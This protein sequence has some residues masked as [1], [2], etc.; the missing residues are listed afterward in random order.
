MPQFGEFLQW[1]RSRYDY[2]IVDTPPLMVVADPAIIANSV[3]GIVLTFRVRRGCRPQVKESA[4]IL[5]AIGKPIFGCVVNRVDDSSTGSGYVD[6]QACSYYHARRY[7]SAASTGGAAARFSGR[8]REFVV[9]GKKSPLPGELDAESASDS[10]V[11]ADPD[12][13]ASRS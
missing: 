3:D 5:R 4:A 9:N 7:T 11:A 2:V 10:D 13:V 12:A 1:L 6:H 8:S